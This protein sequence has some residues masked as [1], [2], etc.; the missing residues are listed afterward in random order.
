MRRRGFTLIELLVVI[1]IIAVLIALLLP[2]VQAAREAARRSQCVNNLKQLGLAI[3]NY[4]SGQGSLPPVG[5]T[6]TGATQS[7]YSMKGRIL[8]NLEQSTIFNSINWS[9][10]FN[11]IVNY[12]ASTASINTYLC[13]SDGNVPGYNVT[14]TFAGSI[15]YGPCNYGNNIGVCRSLN[16]GNFDGPGWWLG[17]T[18]GAATRSGPVVTLAAIV[19]GTSNTAMFSEWVKGKGTAQNGLNMVYIATTTFSTTAPSPAFRGTLGTT[20]T[21]Y[22]ATCTTRTVTTFTHKGAFWAYEGCGSGGGYTHINPPNH[23]ACQ[24]SS[25]STGDTPDLPDRGMI[26]A[27]SYHPGGVNVGFLDGSVKFMKDSTN[28]QTWGSVA[29]MAGGEVIDASSL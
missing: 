5:G 24:F 22:A 10:R 28:L 16:G 1:A 20:L 11:N 3:A 15:P 13:P 9:Y 12:T 27:S 2:A 21:Y 23:P 17:A 6:G 19:D 8:P 18:V 29:T 25:D 14:T 7:D 26:G 4:E